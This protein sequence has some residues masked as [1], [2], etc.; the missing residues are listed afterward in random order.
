MS[1]FVVNVK[2]KGPEINKNIYGHFSEH[3]GRCVYEGLY[4]GEDSAIPNKNG[5][6]TDVVEALKKIHVPV[7]RWPGGCFADVYHWKDGIG[8][9]ETRRRMVN[10]HWGSVIDDNSFGTHE[11]ME[12]C[13]QLQCEPYIAGNMA[14]GTVQEMN[15]WVE[16][17]NYD[18][19]SDF[20]KLR[21]KNGH[22]EAWNVKYFGVGNESWGCG[23]RM[24]PE[25]Y[26][27]EFR[28]YQHY[29]RTYQNKRIYRV[30]CGPN[31]DDYHW[32]DVVMKLAGECMDALSLHY[33]T[34][35]RD[36]E[37]KRGAATGFDK[38]EYYQ[39]IR[40]AL[41]IDEIIKNHDSIMSKY[42]PEHRV[43]LIVDEWGTW[44][45]SEPGTNPAFLYQQNT[46]RDAIVAA[47]SLNIFNQHADR[48]VMANLAQIV[49]VLQ[50]LI[51]TEGEAMVL[52]P[53]YHVFDL[54]RGHQGAVL[55]DNYVETQ[56]TGKEEE[57]IP[58]LQ[59]SAS[60]GT[61]GV[62]HITLVNTDAENRCDIDGILA[63]IE[64]EN[65]SVAARILTG[66]MDA[67]NDFEKSEVN[68]CAFDGLKKTKDGVQFEI[69]PCSVMEITVRP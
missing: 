1:R 30:A 53:T 49:N 41:A 25:Y 65:A 16:Y 28:R 2:K 48:V 5:M 36:Q 47:V 68:I 46:M 18:G 43:G 19:D 23:G 66:K 40:K 67:Y 4:V 51:L 52:T 31:A 55:L 11:F 57:Q 21:A 8:P 10:T 63:G 14:S 3:L 60:E 32:T 20:A 39:T 15:E 29:L 62:I 61:D 58:N 7:L 42:D 9:K 34:V 45:E 26:A 56:M 17:L 64:M 33:Y 24:Y 35:P 59:I 22:K 38:K 37:K 27:H 6:R 44:Y 69:P 13:E 54:Y 12:L 50:A